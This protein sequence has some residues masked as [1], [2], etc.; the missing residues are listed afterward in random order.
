MYPAKKIDSSTLSLEKRYNNQRNSLKYLSL[1]NL[2]KRTLK[3][4]EALK[5]IESYI[6]PLNQVT[7][8]EK[9]PLR[10]SQTERNFLK[11]NNSL[12]KNMKNS[13]IKDKENQETYNY[14]ANTSINLEKNPQKARIKLSFDKSSLKQKVWALI[15]EKQVSKSFITTHN[16][17][18]SINS[19]KEMKKN[20][21]KTKNNSIDNLTIE[22]ANID[23][24]SSKKKEK[25]M[26]MTGTGIVQ[27][28]FDDLNV[29][30]FIYLSLL[31]ISNT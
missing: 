3:N 29:I 8:N 18:F 27:E 16:E 30:F 4:S 15:Q 10:K 13:D 9:I 2:N 22:I 24:V 31:N 21:N 7:K 23:L 17:S 26:N 1:G 19:L 12:P 20:T 6:N 25:I 28:E 14:R 11:P 5:S